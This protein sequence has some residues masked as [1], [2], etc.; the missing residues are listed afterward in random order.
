MIRR[1]PR[2]TLSSSSAASDVYK[3]QVSTQS[4]GSNFEEAMARIL[5]ACALLMAVACASQTEYVDLGQEIAAPPGVE[6]SDRIQALGE[7]ADEVVYRISYN[8]VYDRTQP[9]KTASKGTFKIKIT[10][11]QG[12][13]GELTLVTHPG[14]SCSAKTDPE[15]QT[16]IEGKSLATSATKCL[17]DPAA[18]GYD[19]EKA[20]WRA[21]TGTTQHAVSRDLV[22]LSVLPVHQ[23]PGLRPDQQD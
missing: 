11:D 5:V 7:G 12:D 22:G 10:G 2:S 13:T 1:P 23:G 3:R 18:D 19:E 6:K 15:C 20:N 16:T 4:T 14:Y 17:C 9:E 8:T 21:F